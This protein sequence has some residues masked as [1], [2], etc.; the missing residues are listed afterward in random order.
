M[1]A[2]PDTRWLPQRLSRALE[3]RVL[4][5]VLGLSFFALV[6]MKVASEMWEGDATMVD[7]WVLQLLRTP[8]GL[9]VGP[10]GLPEWARDLTALG[11]PAVLGL[12]TLAAWSM[13]M[14]AGRHAMAWISLGSTLSGLAAAM[15]LKAVFLRSRPDEAFRATV[16]SGYS[17]PSGHAMMSAVVYLT[18]AVL[19]ARTT[20]RPALRL[21]AVV[22]A[23]LVAG[24]V[25]IT[26]IYLG[27]HWAS[28]VVAG[29]TAGAAWAM[30]S[31]LLAEA[32]GIGR[33]R[34]P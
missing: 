9:P 14:A 8:Q 28:D 23:T 31:W 22:M 32:L 15:L 24:L 21:S 25:G 30:A 6:F 27:A 18:L 5:P 16:V 13:L 4:L 34:Q 3:L 12:V 10:A 17:F 1:S 19:L 7:Q 20:Q 2:S 29:W 11:S 33:A 26:R